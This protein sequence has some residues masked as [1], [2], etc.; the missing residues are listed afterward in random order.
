M[1]EGVPGGVVSRIDSRPASLEENGLGA[2]S[3]AG[4][5]ASRRELES[6]STSEGARPAS[7]SIWSG[8]ELRREPEGAAST[9]DEEWRRGLEVAT[10]ARGR[11]RELRGLELGRST[12]GKDERE[13]EAGTSSS[14]R[15]FRRE[16][17]AWSIFRPGSAFEVHTR[18]LERDLGRD[19]ERGL[20]PFVPGLGVKPP[21]SAFSHVR[22]RLSL[23][24]FLPSQ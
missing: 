23:S 24:S 20:V 7:D 14:G 1:D 19:R 2:G 15:E 21:F 3:V 8:R 9:R 11:G 22:H 4:V 18:E 12:R 17:G 16:L 6:P 10:S 13:L 5:G